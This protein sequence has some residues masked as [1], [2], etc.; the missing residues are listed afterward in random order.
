M[1]ILELLKSRAGAIS[2]A[3]VIGLGVTVG[4]VGLNVAN[5][6][7][8]VPGPE[9][10][11]VRDLAQIMS[12]GGELPKE[13]SGIR[14][15]LGNVQLATAEERAAREGNIFDGG[16]AGVANLARLDGMNITGQRFSGGEAGLGM[17]AND[18]VALTGGSAA[19]NAQ[20]KGN[21]DGALASAREQARNQAGKTK[22]NR[23][24]DDSNSNFQ[25][26]SI[27]RASGNE[28]G[29][30]ATG[31]FGAP[32]YGGSGSGEIPS[33]LSGA[34]PSGSTLV[35][36]SGD[37]QGARTPSYVAGSRDARVM[38]AG[39]RRSQEENS[40]LDTAKRSAEAARN[41][42]RADNEGATYAFMSGYQR[43]L[44]L[45]N[46]NDEA[47]SSL[48]VTRNS[49]SDLNSKIPG[50]GNLDKLESNVQNTL[51]DSLEREAK[52]KQSRNSLMALCVTTVLA[53]LV[54]V[55]AIS[56]MRNVPAY[57]TAA[58][59][60]TTAIIVGLIALLAIKAGI[61]WKKYPDDN[62]GWQMELACVAMLTLVGLAWTALGDLLFKGIE[63]LTQGLAKIFGQTGEWADALVG[64]IAGGA[65]TSVKGLTGGAATS[66]AMQGI[67]SLIN[68]KK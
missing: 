55:V 38:G 18:A 1:K 21:V 19:G 11:E 23:L 34:M 59:G 20:V 26:A 13:Y 66:E 52:K 14:V 48:G 42:H 32:S 58:A 24:G 44:M 67:S 4:L 43:G 22:I 31:G 49:D 29:S 12:S 39:G 50:M 64:K 6:F 35:V 8:T 28:L 41:Q 65:G 37:L 46:S 56:V 30:G 7:S 9:S 27:A 17:G 10:Q 40:L 2:K 57:G 60:I 33:A 36:A 54:A 53:T 16:D 5:F 61:H 3:G 51:D 15:S 63:K 62:V 68:G 25:R 47:G 45:D